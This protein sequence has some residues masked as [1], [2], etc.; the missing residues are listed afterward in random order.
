LPQLAVAKDLCFNRG[1]ELP[2][3]SAP[4]VAN[5][6]RHR[7]SV[8]NGSRLFAIQGADARTQTGRRFRDLVE[9]MTNDLGGPSF[10]SEF[11]KQL[12]RRAATLSIMAESI[13]ADVVRDFEFDILN[14]GTVCDRLRR[15]AETLGLQRIARPVDGSTALA[16]YFSHAR[17]KTP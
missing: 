3:D 16:D 7:S 12:V 11:Q 15:I 14:Y 5:T 4:S 10:L 17:P 6:R 13:E 9:T 1:M 8:S 2:I